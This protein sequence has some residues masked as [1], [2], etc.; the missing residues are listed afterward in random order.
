MCMGLLHCL[1]KKYT[2]KVTV[3]PNYKWLEVI[4]VKSPLLG[5]VTLD[6]KKF[7]TL[8]LIF[9][10]P[11]KFLIILHQTHYNSPFYWNMNSVNTR[12]IP[13]YT[14]YTPGYTKNIPKVSEML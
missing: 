10:G 14:K 5:H 2:F 4:S 3:S 7:E 12:S 11:L 1:G 6:I 9:N 13:N 8:P